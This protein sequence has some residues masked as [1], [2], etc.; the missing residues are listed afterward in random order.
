MPRPFHFVTALWGS[1]FTDL[2]LEVIVPTQLSAGNLPAF[3][4]SGTYIVYT[5][6]ADADRMAAHPSFDRLRALMPVEFLV[7]PGFADIQGRYDS[8]QTMSV[9]HRHAVRRAAEQDAYL[10]LPPPDAIHSDGSFD[11]VRRRVAAGAELVLITGIRLTLESFVPAL[12][13]QMPVRDGVLTV[14]P[15]RLVDLAFSHRHDLT[16]IMEWGEERFNNGWPSQ[17]FWF[18]PPQGI[19]AHCWHLHPLAVRPR[20]E[21]VDFTRTIDFDFIGMALDRLPPDKIHIVRD[22]GEIC[23]MELS[24]T[25][26]QSEMVRQAGPFSRSA[27]DRWIQTHLLPHNRDFV[28]TQILYKGSRFTADGVA[29]VATEAQSI[30]DDLADLCTPDVATL[31]E[32]RAADR[33]FL[34]GAGEYGR[35]VLTAA[36]AAGMTNIQGFLSTDGTGVADGLPIHRL[37]DY[38][39]DQYRSDDLI[40]VTSSYAAD[41]IP[42]LRQA[43]IAR[44]ARTRTLLDRLRGP[45]AGES[46][47]PQLEIV[48][49]APA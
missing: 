18:Q 10:I 16:R 25:L 27:V 40:L 44:C 9:F 38:R 23:Q 41:I 12:L 45:V 24:T 47:G 29:S 17:M 1:R 36:R 8:Y 39:R 48:P 37:A 5:T 15:A 31:E 42:L 3:A 30:A 11:A 46:S 49:W 33:I 4:G 19:V 6:E 35:T 7:A 28:R 20:A 2:F 32:V 43:G 14:E 21:M 26:H 22:S 34:Y 13:D